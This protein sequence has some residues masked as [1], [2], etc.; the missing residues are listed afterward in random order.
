M[1]RGRQGNAYV[2]GY[3]YS[4]DFPVTPTAIQSRN[5]G[6]FN[7]FLAKIG[8]LG[9]SRLCSTY[10]GGSTADAA[11][12]IS[13]DTAANAYLTGHAGSSDF[14]ERG[15]PGQH[16]GIQNGVRE[17]LPALHHQGGEEGAYEGGVAC[18]LPAFC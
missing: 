5:A 6:I 1:S 17:R 9:D 11:F 12:G 4:T 16:E 13:L 8:P 15:V 3:T 18:H 14:E 10:P 2:T 7:A